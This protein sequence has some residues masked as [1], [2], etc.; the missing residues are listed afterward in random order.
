MVRSL[1][2]HKR[3]CH[4][5]RG[6]C[7]PSALFI[8]CD[9]VAFNG[10]SRIWHGSGCT[11]EFYGASMGRPEDLRHL[12]LPWGLRKKKHVRY[13][14]PP[15]TRCLSSPVSRFPLSSA[16]PTCKAV[17]TQPE[18]FTSLGFTGSESSLTDPCLTYNFAVDSQAEIMGTQVNFERV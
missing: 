12:T 15:I 5:Y 13:A 8:G 11:W 16:F 3:S 9:L 17:V 7:V 6:L 2:R 1:R 14:Y 10:V 18:I 4:L